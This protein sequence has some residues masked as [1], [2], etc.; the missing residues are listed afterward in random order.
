M[1]PSGSIGAAFHDQSA[2]SG[3]ANGLHAWNGLA[4]AYVPEHTDE[5]DDTFDGSDTELAYSSGT[6]SLDGDFADSVLQLVDNQPAAPRA[7]SPRLA[8]ILATQHVDPISTVWC[9]A[10]AVGM[11]DDSYGVHTDYVRDCAIHEQLAQGGRSGCGGT[12][13]VALSNVSVRSMGE[14]RA[15]ADATCTSLTI[16]SARPQGHH[17]SD[18]CCQRVHDPVA[19]L[20]AEAGAAAN[21]LLAAIPMELLLHQHSAA[22]REQRIA[23]RRRTIGAEGPASIRRATGVVRK[24]V[25]FVQRHSIPAYGIGNDGQVDEDTILWFLAEVDK[26]ARDAAVGTSRTGTSA[27]HTTAGSLRWLCDHAGLPFAAAKA[28]YVRRSSAPTTSSEPR[29]AEMWEVAVLVHLLRIAVQYKGRGAAFVRPYAASAYCVAA[30]SVRLVDALRSA[31]PRLDDLGVFATVAVLSKG[32]RRS[33]MRPL[34]WGVPAVSPDASVDDAT[35]TAGLLAAFALMPAGTST[36]FPAMVDSRGQLANL[37]HATGWG[38]GRSSDSRL[39]TSVAYLLQWAPLS[40]SRVEA[41]RVASKKHAPRHI[42]PE[43]GRIRLWPLPARLELGYWKDARGGRMAQ[44]NRYSRDAERLLQRQLRTLL[45][46]LVRRHLP[47]FKRVPL[48]R[49]AAPPDE[50]AVDSSRA[51]LA[52]TEA[53]NSP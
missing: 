22:P 39:I 3:S 38:A 31:P 25:A 44:P 19:V 42:L 33:S 8:S 32:R 23:T 47:E 36:M 13:L 9:C 15:R 43:L 34:P 21:E 20:D 35:L 12:G 53:T 18:R 28:R 51:Q 10:D 4:P 24:W 5:E 30:G 6:E 1:A 11:D 40:Y 14:S 52:I 27:E 17:S 45:L 37:Q 50:V 2:A 16:V 41:R 46:Q 49:F 48:E 7:M 29:W 26:E